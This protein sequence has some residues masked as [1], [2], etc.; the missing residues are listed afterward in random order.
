MHGILSIFIRCARSAVFTGASILT[1]SPASLV[2][3]AE[4]PTIVAFGDSTTAIRGT[5]TVY[6][7]LLQ[8]EL[9]GV[10]V[11]NA[12]VG[13][14]TTQMALKRLETDVLAHAPKLVIVQFGINDAA[15]DL[16]KT[17]PAASPRVPLEQYVQN[18]RTI[19]Q[20]VKAKG[21][22]V[23]LM[24]P[25]PMRWTPILKEKYG[26]PPYEVDKPEGF[27]TP[28]VPYCEAMTKL[29]QEEEVALINVQELFRTY[30]KKMNL[31]VDKLLLDGM[32]PNDEGQRIVATALRECILQI[33]REK[34][35]T[36]T[37]GPVWQASGETVTISPECT[38][39]THDSTNAAVLGC[40]MAK[41][42]DG[43]MMTVYSTPSSYYAKPGQTW[44]ATRVTKDGGKTWSA[45]KEIARNADCQ[46]SH[47]SVLRAKDGTLHVFHL[48]FKGW[49]WK[50][51][52]PTNV[53]QSDVYATRSS[54]EGAT[55]TTPQPIFDGYSGATN[56]AIETKDGTLLVP[57]SHYVNDPGRLVSRVSISTDGGKT[58][59][60]GSPIDIGGA[61]DHEGA[62]EPSLIQLRDGRVWMLIRTTRGQFW[63]SYSADAGKT[64]T[65]AMAGNISATSAPGHMTRLADGRIALVWNKREKN[66]RELSLALSTDD[67][68]T[69][70]AAVPLAKGKSTTYPFV[71]EGAPGELWVGYHDVPKSWN[72]PR[73]RALKIQVNPVDPA[74]VQ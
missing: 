33:A 6:A 59:T 58:W 41:L 44:I 61:G 46:A 10:K 43:S 49:K 31:E 53:A 47:P 73:G 9:R 24:T 29:A 63:N 45:E 7:T 57:Y 71:I 37:P 1:L 27:N 2:K 16:W 40:G 15:V 20:A 70:S 26:K 22:Q 14:N 69:W 34:A 17:P 23:I 64:W 55:W 3:A 38:D 25:N 8:E 56:G 39:I 18:L 72:F 50:G 66:R 74:T 12:G 4:P 52:N 36:I 51:V 48:A 42:K 67:G 62:L 19:V 54:D 5:L 32:H 21:A 35:L 13:G 68:E 30:A 11:I 60:L 28:M 65:A